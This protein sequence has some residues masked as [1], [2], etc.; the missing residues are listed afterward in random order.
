MNTTDSVHRSDPSWLI[1][2]TPLR[3]RTKFA[4]ALITALGGM[5]V[6]TGAETGLLAMMVVLF[7]FI[8]FVCVDWQKLFSLPPIV[9]YAA[10]ALTA[11]VCVADFVQEA[12]LLGRKMV[13]VAQLLAVAQA[14]L[15][16]QEKSQR[17]FEQL[18][19]FAL[20][21]CVVAAVFND[22]FNY[23]IWFLPLTFATGLALAFLAADQTSEDTQAVQ[24]SSVKKAATA[25]TATHRDVGYFTWNNAAAV[26]SIG[27]VSLRLPWISLLVLVPAISLFACTFFFALPRRIEPQRGS[28][29]SALV[30]FS[31]TVNL[32]QISRM[33]M[34]D[35]RALQVRL[36]SA[37][38]QRP[39]PVVD[40]IYLRGLTLEQYASGLDVLDEGGSWSTV[41]GKS[42]G[43]VQALPLPFIPERSSDS[44]FF[45]PVHVDVTIESMRTP[46]LFAIAPYHVIK[47]SERLVHHPMQ[48]IFGRR[49][50]KTV[51][52]GF[53]YPRVNYEF[54]TH[55]F[56]N[57]IQT[58]WIS[59]RYSFETQVSADENSAVAPLLQMTQTEM[60][61]FDQITH[62]PEQSLPSVLPLVQKV[63][64][65]IPPPQRTSVKIAR[66][67]EAHFTASG[68][69]QYTLD[70]TDAPMIGVDPIEQF[71]STHHR[72]HCQFFASALAMMLRSQN[73]PARLVVGYH[74]D[75]FNELS[76]SFI[77]R[78]RHAH[79]WVEALIDREELPLSESIYGQP[80]SNQ[81]W[82]RL[83]P[84]PG[85]GLNSTS[86]TGSSQIV[87][88]AQNFWN[89]Q[90]VEM[91]SERQRT[92]LSSAPGFSPMT[93]SYRSWIE[94]AQ[95]L[96]IRINAGE[97]K[98]LGGGKLFSL[99]AAVATT[100]IGFI[101]FIILKMPVAV[102]FRKRWV[103]GDER[104][105]PKPT[106]AFYA[107]TLD[108]LEK[109]GLHRA[110]GQTP[111]ELVA[112]IS[113]PKINGPVA[114]LTDWF[115]RL[116]YGQSN[117]TPHS[118][119]SDS[120]RKDFG[121]FGAQRQLPAQ[122]DASVEIET[123][124]QVLR[125]QVDRN[126]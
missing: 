11:I 108:L 67:L 115:Y 79:A 42:A 1:R 36:S 76:Q 23:A 49:K 114:N 65:R 116:R 58:D 34:T 125:E 46:A 119:R 37:G 28:P 107:E 78:Q 17:L 63:I 120:G 31:E 123:S 50:A 57:G 44:N 8:G 53:G 27:S 60:N 56:R 82:L 61:Y 16:L 48:S 83:D 43:P 5:V 18:L 75:E 93:Q 35:E 69:Y 99:P 12:N 103:V 2:D 126:A 85:G 121:R 32:G 102:L 101:L 68:R 59:H 106:L 105:A 33:Q 15:M 87:D 45:D 110:T 100:G 41:S 111:N 64:N 70:L 95:D 124:L 20:L 7:A 52:S 14:I 122:G 109:I 113:Q 30:G 89:E 96:A 39:Y 66:S 19:V 81:Y 117:S 6:G 4:F 104:R 88:L 22:A 86:R 84:T 3:L 38:T 54:G 92:V 73:I 74:C 112:S 29:K 118:D 9:A 90:V 80:D 25:N 21:N 26:Q 40:G 94:K 47:G 51:D 98:G 97:V 71:L 10:M 24:H 13:A 55:A 91:S 77:V 62:F 72:G